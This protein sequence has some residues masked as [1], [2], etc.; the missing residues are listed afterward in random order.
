MIIKFV[1]NETVLLEGHMKVTYLEGD[2]V[3]M[4]VEIAKQLVGKGIAK[5]MEPPVVAAVERAPEHK[6]ARSQ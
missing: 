2:V 6:K 3:D 1:K 4:G 5:S